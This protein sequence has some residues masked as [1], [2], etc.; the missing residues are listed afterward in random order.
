MMEL[1]MSMWNDILS[2]RKQVHKKDCLD[3][4]NL[5][6]WD[7]SSI[8]A[9]ENRS[10]SPCSQIG[11]SNLKMCFGIERDFIITIPPTEDQDTQK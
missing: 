8:D 6:L 3:K 10:S 9:K 4:C 7:G 11:G 5:Q 2:I 1:H